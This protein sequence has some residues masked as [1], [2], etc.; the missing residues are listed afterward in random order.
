MGTFFT[1]FCKMF[2]FTHFLTH[3]EQFLQLSWEKI[4]K[5]FL[6]HTI[7]DFLLEKFFDQL[8]SKIYVKILQKHDKNMLKKTQTRGALH[9]N[10]PSTLGY[11]LQIFADA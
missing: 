3:F 7:F 6:S 8:T 11:F 5:K 4:K 1:F 10:D 9:L 2:E